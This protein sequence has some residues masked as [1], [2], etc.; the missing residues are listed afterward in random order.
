MPV[1]KD[2]REEKYCQLRAQGLILEEAYEK[3]GWKRHR[4][5]A[6]RMSA[7]E[8]IKAR[9][10]E[11]LAA[12]AQATGI[13]IERVTHDLLRIAAKAEALGSAPGLAVSRAAIV[14]AANINGLVIDR[15]EIGAPGEFGRMDDEELRDFIAGR[16]SSARSGLGRAAHAGDQEEP[17]GPGR[18]N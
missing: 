10:A 18:P 4:G 2:P 16:A 12:A 17:Q 15:R 14:D 5:N 11:I 6:A 7:R 1:L 3:A 9:I 13:T 8:P